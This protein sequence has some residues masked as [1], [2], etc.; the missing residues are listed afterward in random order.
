MPSIKYNHKISKFFIF[1]QKCTKHTWMHSLIAIS[2]DQLL[3]RK[4]IKPF[5]MQEKHIIYKSLRSKNK[6]TKSMK[7]KMKKTIFHFHCF[8]F[9]IL[10]AVI[11]LF[12]LLIQFQ[13]HISIFMVNSKT[14]KNKTKYKEWSRV[15]NIVI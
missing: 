14:N 2:I 10:V 8:F 5:E 13:Y 1:Q 7:K 12:F 6:N 15:N 3:R 4:Q 9:S 11:F